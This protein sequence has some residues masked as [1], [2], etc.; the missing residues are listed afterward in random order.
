MSKNLLNFQ[1][2]K[3]ESTTKNFESQTPQNPSIKTQ[4]QYISPQYPKTLKNKKDTRQNC[5]F[6]FEKYGV[7]KFHKNYLVTSCKII[8]DYIYDILKISCYDIKK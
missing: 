2:W 6:T 5:L 8:T 3:I 4:T 7:F 1:K